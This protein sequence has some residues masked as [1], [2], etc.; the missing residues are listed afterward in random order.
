[1]EHVTQ[2]DTS[3]QALLRGISSAREAREL[4]R[5]RGDDGSGGVEVGTCHVMA[6]EEFLPFAPGSFDLVLRCAIQAAWCRCTGGSLA[7]LRVLLLERA[8][9]AFW[10]TTAAQAF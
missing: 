7:Y 1:M 5:E 3:E 10:A 9:R 6:D 4:A 8:G 2:C